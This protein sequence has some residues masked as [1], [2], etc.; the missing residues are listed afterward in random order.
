MDQPNQDEIDRFEMDLWKV[1]DPKIQDRTLS[2]ADVIVV[3]S[4]IA[5]VLLT[6]GD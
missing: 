3:L 6:P 4:K 1:I 5:T 2:I